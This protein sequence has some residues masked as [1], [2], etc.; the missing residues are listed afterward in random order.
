M[1]SHLLK[2]PE[3]AATAWFGSFSFIIV[4][5]F[6]GLGYLYLILKKNRDE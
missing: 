6:V 5:G 2:D 4:L 3:G 1:E